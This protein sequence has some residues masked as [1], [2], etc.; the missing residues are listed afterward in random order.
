M[1][2]KST[3]AHIQKRVREGALVLFEPILAPGESYCRRLWLQRGV[4]DWVETQGIG[5]E[6]RFFDDVRAFLKSFVTGEDFDDDVK[7]KMLNTRTGGWYEFRITFNPQTRL[8]GGF[9]R[10]GEFVVVLQQDRRSLGRTSFA[11]A[12]QR[13]ERIWKGLFPNH[14]PVTDRRQFLLKDFFDGEQDNTHR[15]R[16]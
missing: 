14:L 16:R 7:L 15:R 6:E 10:S 9:L 4:A 8:F 3:E 5:K 2:S 11:P 13:A 12:I 1:T